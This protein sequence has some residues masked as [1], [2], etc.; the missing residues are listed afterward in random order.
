MIVQIEQPVHK[1]HIHYC[2]LVYV[3]LVFQRML[4]VLTLMSAYKQTPVALTKSVSTQEVVMCAIHVHQ[5][6]Y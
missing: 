4:I 3:S 6:Q 2:M 1:E 5:L